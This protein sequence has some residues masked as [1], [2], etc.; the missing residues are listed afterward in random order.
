MMGVEVADYKGVEWSSW[1]GWFEI[2]HATILQIWTFI[3][4]K[5]VSLNAVAGIFGDRSQVKIPHASKA[6]AKFSAGCV[7]ATRA[8]RRP[9]GFSVV[10]VC[11]RCGWRAGRP[12]VCTSE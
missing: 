5:L 2:T 11:G 3:K 7:C 4:R 10:G 8:S 12:E 9:A 6:Q 1:R